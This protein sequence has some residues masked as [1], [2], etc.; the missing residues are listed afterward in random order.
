MASEDARAKAIERAQVAVD[1]LEAEHRVWERG[2]SFLHLTPQDLL[3]LAKSN[4]RLTGAEAEALDEA[5]SQ[6][7]GEMLTDPIE[8]S[9]RHSNNTSQPKELP[10]DKAMLSYRD[11]AGILGVSVA[12]I[13]RMIRDK[14]LAR[15]VKISERRVGWQ[16]RYIDEWLES[17]G[18]K[19]R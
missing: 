6:T 12:T 19:R 7:F 11:V 9:Q 17:R 18:P 8:R 2:E 13:K 16:R 10:P 3:K 14:R 5:W 15:P 4:R 1:R